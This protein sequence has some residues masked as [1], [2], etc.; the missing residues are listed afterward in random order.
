MS[1]A[2]QSGI[3]VVQP[4]IQEVPRPLMQPSHIGTVPAQAPVQESRPFLF[5][6]GRDTSLPH[7]QSSYPPASPLLASQLAKTL[8]VPDTDD[9]EIGADPDE[10]AFARGDVGA[11]ESVDWFDIDKLW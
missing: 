4:H 9:E 2:G 7:F 5:Q 10:V 8:N 1:Y 3:P 6:G 11:E